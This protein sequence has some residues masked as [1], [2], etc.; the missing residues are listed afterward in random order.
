MLTTISLS[1][2]AHNSRLAA[3]AV[4]R[5]HMSSSATLWGGRPDDLHHLDPS[6]LGHP[7]PARPRFMSASVDQPVMRRMDFAIGNM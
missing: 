2:T 6:S 1:F 3:A 7:K 4:C 5:K